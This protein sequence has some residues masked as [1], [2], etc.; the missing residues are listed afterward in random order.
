M[1]SEK[2]NSQYSFQKNEILCL[3]ANQF[4]HL[5]KSLVVTYTKKK[6]YANK[7]KKRKK[8]KHHLRKKTA[9][10]EKKRQIEN[11]HKQMH[12]RKDQN[13]ININKKSTIYNTLF[14]CVFMQTTLY[15]QL[16]D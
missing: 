7:T 6:R 5:I 11:N 2:K 14:V 9:T 8:N 1:S 10:K 13:L 16:S 15:F 12:D 3:I 4:P